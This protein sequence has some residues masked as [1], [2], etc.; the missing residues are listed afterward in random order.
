MRGIGY[1]IPPETEF[2][3]HCSNLQVWFENNYDTRLLHS[4]LAFPLLKRLTEVGDNQ[5]KNVF[6]EE[7]VK[8]LR[9]GVF[10]TFLFLFETEYISYLS[11][12][13]KELVFLDSNPKLEKEIKIAS[14]IVEYIVEKDE[15]LFQSVFISLEVLKHLE[16]IGDPQAK[17]LF[18]QYLNSL[19]KS[20]NLSNT[21]SLFIKGYHNFLQIKE[22]ELIYLNNNYSLRK[23]I[24]NIL[25][26]PEPRESK[27]HSKIFKV[28]NGLIELGD[29]DAK[30]KEKFWQ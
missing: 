22:K 9:S 10:N 20:G 8:R 25:S 30:K 15:E 14:N 11:K 7:I 12:D 24:E 28:L 18:R 13:E 26:L 4:N 19:F 23:N 5:A 21:H 3:G 2:W 1:I 27:D 17:R 6:N 16:N 29:E